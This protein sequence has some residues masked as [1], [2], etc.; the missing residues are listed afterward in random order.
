MKHLKIC[1]GRYTA[2]QHSVTDIYTP[3]LIPKKVKQIKSHCRS[4]FKQWINQKSSR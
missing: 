4:E 1:F 2:P 3:R